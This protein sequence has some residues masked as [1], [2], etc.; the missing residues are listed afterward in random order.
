MIDKKKRFWY[1]SECEDGKWGPRCQLNCGKCL[2][3]PCNHVNGSC[4]DGC[5]PG[6]KPTK[7]C[8]TGTFEK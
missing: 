7:E 4:E 2:S 5:V 6:Y 3:S 8:N 1:F